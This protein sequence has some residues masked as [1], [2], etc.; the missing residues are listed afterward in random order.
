MRPDA[1]LGEG[2][3]IAFLDGAMKIVPLA[4]SLLFLGCGIPRDSDGALKRIQNGTLRVG[5]ADDP[6]WVVVQDTSVSGIEPTL[7]TELA[8]QLN[9]RVE[10][11]HGSETRLL[12]GLHRRELDIV[13]GGFTQDSPWKRDVAFTRSYH[14]D[15]DGRKH[16]FA[17]APGENGLLMRVEQFLHQNESRLKGLPE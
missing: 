9:A 10:T 3:P 16:V 1:L 17:L 13:I 2:Q 11:V 15:K 5:V 6:P 12:E 8:R 4:L 7:V 14:D